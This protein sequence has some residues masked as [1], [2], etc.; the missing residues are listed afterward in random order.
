MSRNHKAKGP[1]DFNPLQSARQS[2]AK[3]DYKQALKDAKVAWRQAPTDECRQ[4][5]ERAYVERARQLLRHG[6]HQESRAVLED[7]YRLGI[8]QSSVRDDATP[9]AISVGLFEKAVA[10]S[11]ASEAV[12]DPHIAGMIAD[13]AVLY[14]DQAPASL[15]DV[16][17]QA[18]DVRTAL[19]R[20]EAGD[21]EGA[22]AALKD[23][24]RNSPF[25]DWRL[26]VRGLAAYY[27]QDFAEMRSSWDRLEPGRAASRIAQPLREL[28][29]AV[30]SGKPVPDD[31]AAVRSLVTKIEIALFGQPMLPRLYELRSRAAEEDWDGVLRILRRFCQPLRGRQP[32]FLDRLGQVLLPIV[33]ERGSTELME[34]LTETLAGPPTD[35]HWNRAWALFLEHPEEGDWEEAEEYWKEYLKDLKTLPAFSPQERKLAQALVWRWIGRNWLLEADE[36]F[37]RSQESMVEERHARNLAIKAFRRSLALA[38]DL[39][40]AYYDLA[41]TQHDC[42]QNEAAEKTYKQL[43]ARFPDELDALRSIVQ[44]LLGRDEP[45]EALEY[46]LRAQHLKPLDRQLAELAAMC[47]MGAARHHALAG[48]WEEG[49]ACLAAAEALGETP[50]G[51]VPLLA[52]RA[53]FEFKAGEMSEGRRWA[54]EA[55]QHGD[56]VAVL[57]H[58][59]IEAERYEVGDQI[60]LGFERDWKDGLKGKCRSAAAGG[61]ARLLLAHLVTGTRFAGLRTY[62]NLV[63][64][65][66][67]RCR[68]VKW[69]ENDLRD[70]CMFLQMLLEQGE[71][72]RTE[73]L[74]AEFLSRGLKAFPD[75]PFFHWRA[76]EREVAEGPLACDRPYARYLARRAAELAER[77]GTP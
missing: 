26:L 58:L 51:P 11:Q 21:A 35:P 67:G 18:M 1:K 56:P 40:E 65:Y 16:R 76:C 36:A 61:M 72:S 22:Q 37:P 31:R 38:P 63:V 39:R 41:R 53:A 10:K 32:E 5:L 20:L 74:V 34:G 43:L 55:F 57:L 4:F 3:L 48:R 33:I 50:S 70:V 25:A 54:L 60:V 46:V 62:L 19:A 52:R 77:A 30:E 7:L 64:T 71:S 13:S 66:L 45:L 2:F 9:L 75:S 44:L 8:T 42:G 24:P 47:R 49:R 29:E 68:R 15:P 27:R 69:A 6:L 23:I 12:Q 17:R 73:N 14:P 59:L 28:A